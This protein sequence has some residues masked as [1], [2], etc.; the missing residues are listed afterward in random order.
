MPKKTDYEKFADAMPLHRDVH[1]VM[2][3]DS[4]IEVATEIDTD[5]G[6]GIPVGWAIIGLRWVIEAVALPSWVPSWNISAVGCAHIQLLRGAKPNT[7]A[8][9]DR[10]HHDVLGEDIV[11]RATATAVGGLRETWPRE[12]PFEAV[13]QRPKLH[14]VFGTTVDFTEISATTYRVAAQVIYRL[15]GA[16][17]ARHEDL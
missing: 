10:F 6:A 5:I 9:K 11:E 15:V 14:L 1:V 7:P 17:P 3:T 16:P 4:T 12:V 13:T 8:L 2:G